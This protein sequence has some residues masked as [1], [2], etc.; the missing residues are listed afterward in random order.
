LLEEADRLYVSAVF[1]FEAPGAYFIGV[2]NVVIA[3]AVGVAV[4]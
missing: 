2:G 4:L 1:F 3:V